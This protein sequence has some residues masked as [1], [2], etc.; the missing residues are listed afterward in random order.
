MDW[1]ILVKSILVHKIILS[2]VGRERLPLETPPFNMPLPFYILYICSAMMIFINI[3]KRRVFLWCVKVNEQWCLKERHD[4]FRCCVLI[5]ALQ[6]TVRHIRVWINIKFLPP[7][8]TAVYIIITIYMLS[9]SKIFVSEKTF[10]I[11]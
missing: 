10:R 4:P 11:L 3:E 5:A 1:Y 7:E 6:T 2:N 9:V 8:S